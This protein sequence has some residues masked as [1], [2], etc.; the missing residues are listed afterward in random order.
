MVEDRKQSTHIMTSPRSENKL[1]MLNE[2]DDDD[3]LSL[4]QVL[5]CTT[6]HYNSPTSINFVH[7]LILNDFKKC[8]VAV[9]HSKNSILRNIIAYLGIA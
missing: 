4:Q 5:V 1:G 7:L 2:D 8:I 9:A 3:K 6:I